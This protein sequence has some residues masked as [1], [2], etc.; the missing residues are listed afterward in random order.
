MCFTY[1]FFFFFFKA[2]FVGSHFPNP[3]L[4]RGQGRESVESKL[5]DY[6]GAR[7]IHYLIYKAFSSH[8]TDEEVEL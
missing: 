8:F 5:L 7:Y 6:Q 1:I 4:N 2:Q 3:G